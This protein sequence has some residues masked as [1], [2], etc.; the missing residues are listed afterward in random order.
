MAQQSMQQEPNASVVSER[1]IERVSPRDGHALFDNAARFF[2]AM[3]GED[4]AR[5]YDAGGFNGTLDSSEVQHVATLRR[6]AQ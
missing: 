6:F 1:H 2:L 5:R 3:S 4:F